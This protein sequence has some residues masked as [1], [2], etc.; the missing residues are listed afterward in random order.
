MREGERECQ[1]E[2]K[3]K[4]DKRRER[5][6]CLR[7]TQTEQMSSRGSSRSRDADIGTGAR[8]LSTQRHI[9]TGEKTTEPQ[10]SRKQLLQDS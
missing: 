8:A 1:G 6:L 4:R 5:A 10:L 3:K 7:N 9:T 2:V